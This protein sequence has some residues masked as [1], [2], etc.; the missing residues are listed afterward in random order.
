VDIRVIQVMLGQKKLD[1]T[2]KYVQVATE[3]LY[4]MLSPLETLETLL[5]T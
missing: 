5:S 1:N 4:E 3:A 2:A